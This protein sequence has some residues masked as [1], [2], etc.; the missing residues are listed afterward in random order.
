MSSIIDLI[1]N[2]QIKID[3]SN[4]KEEIDLQI[5]GLI[6]Y[7]Y[8]YLL[9]FLKAK[10]LNKHYIR[11]E[12]I[13]SLCKNNK[14]PYSLFNFEPEGEKEA[15]Q[16]K[17]VK[18]IPQTEQR[19]KE[20][21]NERA[22]MLTASELS[23]AFNDN[24]YK[25]Q[26][27][28]IIDKIIPQPRMNNRFCDHGIKYEDAVIL[29]YQRDNNCIVDTNFGCIKHPRYT[30]LGA[31]PDGI[32]N[33]GRMIE[34]KCTVSREITGI[35]PIYYWY[36]MQ[37][38]M[39]VANLPC[40][41]FVEC[42]FVEYDDEVDFLNDSANYNILISKDGNKKGV[43]IEY[44]DTI[45]NVNKFKY[46]IE[47]YDYHSV[48]EHSINDIIKSDNLQY[49]KT[50]YWKL[51]I[52]SCIKVYRDHEWFHENFSTIRTFWNEVIYH[53]LNGVDELIQNKNKRKRNKNKNETCMI[54]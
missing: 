30:F 11:Q 24:P 23:T 22:L 50:T 16:Y 34:I 8:E 36:Q 45:E 6:E 44:F 3:Y 25:T 47:N 4:T 7:F 43:I 21:Y 1:D 5:N 12:I 54:D 18:S 10:Q 49:I 52:Y 35:P 33:T 27:N 28:Y 39:E 15:N 14:Y 31:S 19:S 41:D 17:F 29:V 48:Q 38:Q 32:T 40:C 13:R 2:H 26:N 51:P 9:N 37:L 53:R 46:N 20:W 42:K